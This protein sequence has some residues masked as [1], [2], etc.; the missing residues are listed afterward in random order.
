MKGK[1]AL[2]VSFTE[3]LVCVLGLGS[4][5]CAQTASLAPTTLRFPK[6]LIGT[7]SAPKV[8]TLT[9][10]DSTTTL[11]INSI[12]T[13]GDL[14][15]T[16]T[17]GSAVPPSSSCTIIVTFTPTA[18]DTRN[19]SL[20]VND[21]STTGTTQVVSLTSTCITALVKPTFLTYPSQLIKP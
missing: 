16:D 11:I 19:G 20:T 14:G 17:C 1:H 8:V 15:E 12:S 10:T 3:V 9:N 18:S 21:N 13:S 7:T 5:V 6:Q 4:M 2:Q